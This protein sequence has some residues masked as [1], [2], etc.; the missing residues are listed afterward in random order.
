MTVWLV[1]IS[2]AVVLVA[3][4]GLWYHSHLRHEQALRSRICH[5][6]IV[7]LKT[8][9]SFSGILFDRDAL[10]MVLRSA[11]DLQP[12]APVPVDGELLIR[13]ENVAYVQ[14]P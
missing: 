7:T 12:Q 1:V 13:W 5:E 11:A 8:G 6:V 3:Q 14:L 2:T 4:V 9:E 10:V